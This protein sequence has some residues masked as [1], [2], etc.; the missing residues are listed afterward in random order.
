M[1]W[2]LLAFVF[3]GRCSGCTTSELGD[4]EAALTTAGWT[5]NGPADAAGY[6]YLARFDGFEDSRCI[7]VTAPEAA[8]STRI[9]LHRFGTYGQVEATAAPPF[10]KRPAG[11]HVPMGEV[12]FSANGPSANEAYRLY[13]G[14]S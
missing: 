12:M 3:W 4:V 10:S 7:E 13:A 11:K 2:A 8:T 1:R 6:E 9:C 14:S 5:V